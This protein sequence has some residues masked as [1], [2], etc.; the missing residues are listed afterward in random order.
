MKAEYK[1]IFNPE[2][3]SDLEY[4]KLI[5]NAEVYKARLIEVDSYL[6]NKLKYT[7]LT[8]ETEKFFMELRELIYSDNLELN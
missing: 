4:I 2:K 8:E 5:Q 7:E 3:S 1:I 6:R